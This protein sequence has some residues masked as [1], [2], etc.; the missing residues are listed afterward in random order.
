MKEPFSNTQPRLGQAVFLGRIPYGSAWKLQQLVAQA[1][2]QAKLPDTLLLCEHDHV[3]TVGRR[4]SG[5]ANIRK[6]LF[7]VYA[8]ERGGDVTYHG[9]GQLVGY[10][11]C[12]LVASQ[13]PA[14]PHGERDAVAYLRAL[15]AGLLGLLSE[16]GLAVAR[17]PNHTGIWTAD[18]C[19]KIA[20]LGVA[21]RR[22][23]TL[24]GFAL[25]VTTDLSCFAA[26][27]P[28]GLEA[29]V[30]TSV[31]A[32]GVASCSVLELVP[33]C[34]LHVGVALGRHFPLYSPEQ[35]GLSPLLEQAHAAPEGPLDV[36]V[37]SA[38]GG[39]CNP[40]APPDTMGSRR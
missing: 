17:K 20:S 29:Q 14:Q 10:P 27:N 21:V 8:V 39:G 28:C 25:N 35:A 6:P 36:T 15:E 40:F 12:A 26:I 24:H 38:V 34:A 33:K 4:P 9:P 7:P 30:M 3:L 23:V 32:L 31:K 37:G 1:V 2:E 22:W 11:I 16:L 18:G 5:L 19:R 13:N